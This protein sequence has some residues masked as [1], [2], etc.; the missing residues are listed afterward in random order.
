MERERELAVLDSTK[1]AL[2]TVRQPDAGFGWSVCQNRRHLRQLDE[3]IDHRGG[4]CR[5]AQHVQVA[6]RLGPTAQATA[7]LGA[8]DLRMAPDGL[9][10][11]RDQ[12]QSVVLENPPS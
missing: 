7:I 10:N 11:R 6:D 12:S 1:I 9:Q 8:N 4:L 3:G 2:D 5:A